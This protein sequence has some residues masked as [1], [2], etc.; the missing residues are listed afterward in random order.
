MDELH[1]SR[2]VDELDGGLEPALHDMWKLDGTELT[3]RDEHDVGGFPP[4]PHDRW[5]SGGKVPLS[6]HAVHPVRVKMF[7]LPGKVVLQDIAWRLKETTPGG[8]VEKLECVNIF[9][10]KLCE[11]ET[12]VTDKL[13]I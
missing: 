10:I 6:P 2:F 3:S 13:K 9:L 1:N 5:I 4:V 12:N 11:L 7:S 8:S